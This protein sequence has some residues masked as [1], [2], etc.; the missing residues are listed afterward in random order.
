MIRESG[1]IRG[2][3]SNFQSSNTPETRHIGVFETMCIAS[4]FPATGSNFRVI[5]DMREPTVLY[6]NG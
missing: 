4:P 1:R 2:G 6:L 5:S 3:S